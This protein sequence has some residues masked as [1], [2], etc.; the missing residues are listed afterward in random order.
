MESLCSQAFEAMTEGVDCFHPELERANVDVLVYEPLRNEHR[1][2]VIIVQGREMT[3]QKFATNLL[4]STSSRKETVRSTF[5]EAKLIFPGAPLSRAS[6]F[7]ER[8]EPSRLVNQLLS[9]QK[10]PVLRQYRPPELVLIHQWFD[11]WFAKDVTQASAEGY[12][13]LGTLEL[14]QRQSASGDFYSGMNTAIRYLYSL[15]LP[16]VQKPGPENVVLIGDGQRCAVALS[17]LLAWDGGLSAAVVGINRWLPQ[18]KQIQE[19][20]REDCSGCSYN[21]EYGIGETFWWPDDVGGPSDVQ[22][23]WPTKAVKY[24]RCDL[25]LQETRRE[26]SKDVPAFLG[27][28]KISSIA[29]LGKEEKKCLDMVGVKAEM[30]EYTSEFRVGYFDEMMDDVFAFIRASIG[31]KQ[32]K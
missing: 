12:G 26:V 11:Y 29:E 22:C 17:T 18:S 15:I 30:K 31:R 6:M 19:F 27:E 23:D 5:L 13:R 20:A 7:D 8:S 2:T 21:D 16:E 9:H 1:Q 3:V 25:L 4:S 14:Y 28:S 32:T 10:N 24:G